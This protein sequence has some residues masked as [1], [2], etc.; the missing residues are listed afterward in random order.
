MAEANAQI[1][2]S[3]EVD[4]G[5]VEAPP[6]NNE[7]EE[8]QGQYTL[9]GAILYLITATSMGF[10]FI[11]YAFSLVGIPI[12]ILLSIICFR[13]ALFSMNIWLRV[14]CTVGGREVS[15]SSVCDEYLPY[16]IFKF[17]FEAV[18]VFQ[19]SGIATICL[20]IASET[21]VS[22]VKDSG[23]EFHSSMVFVHRY[24]W[25][26][27]IFF[28]LAYPISLLKRLRKYVNYATVIMLLYITSV[29]LAYMGL[30]IHDDESNYP[31][32]EENIGII[33][34]PKSFN[35][36]MVALMLLT[37]CFS[38]SSHV[39]YIYNN[40]KGHRP[41][42]TMKKA[43]WWYT[44]V[45]GL[46]FVSVGISSYMAIGES[47]RRSRHH[48]M[49][50]NYFS[51]NSPQNSMYHFTFL[52]TAADPHFITLLFFKLFVIVMCVVGYPTQI[53]IAKEALVRI[54]HRRS[55][56]IA[57]SD[58]L[59]EPV[60]EKTRFQ[61]WYQ[62]LMEYDKSTNNSFR[63]WVATTFTCLG[64]LI[65][66]LLVDDLS[67]YVEIVG[68]FGAVFLLYIAVPA[69]YFYTDS[70]PLRKSFQKIFSLIT[71]CFGCVILL[72]VFIKG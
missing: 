42:K 65:V 12:G 5:V 35:D 58:F 4:L 11:P 62:W 6:H 48:L 54:C 70:S 36:V 29:S 21:M 3:T 28:F 8:I 7:F 38:C 47:I 1:I 59:K 13:M 22:L 23:I 43:A 60:T 57:M 19:A 49:Y 45:S 33:D 15:I 17:L 55:P 16:P 67:L 46:V 44:V 34:G 61:R 53:K 24:F 64:T 37:L 39:L 50:M 25:S 40:T 56:K 20:V 14:L 18:S 31:S 69:M 30:R 51:S 2:K 72:G 63:K 10:I 71:I 52:L 41:L 26:L 68:A 32:V 66:A 9:T 27:L